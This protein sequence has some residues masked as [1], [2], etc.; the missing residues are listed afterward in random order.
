MTSGKPSETCREASAGIEVITTGYPSLDLIFKVNKAP[1]VGET[2]IISSLGRSVTYG[3]CGINVAAG[4]AKLGRK[5]AV[6][7]VVGED[8]ESTGY[9]A[10]LRSLGVDLTAVEVVPGHLTSRS[11]LYTTPEGEHLNFFYPG[12]ADVWS[13]D[14]IPFPDLSGARFAVVTVGPPR[15]NQVFVDQVTELSIPI[16]LQFRLDS[17]SYLSKDLGGLLSRC[18]ILLANRY[19]ADYLVQELRLGGYADLM[20]YVRDF[21]VITE[22]ENGVRVVSRD[23]VSRV[24][25]VKP[26][27][28]VD[29]TGAGD[30]FTAGLLYGLLRGVDIVDAARTGAALAS[31]VIEEVGCQTNLPS[32]Q[33]LCCRMRESYGAVPEGLFDEDYL[34]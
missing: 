14:T 15:Y 10:H 33:S 11:Y 18:R 13:N 27:R 3:G 28:I 12:A 17:Y 23:G 7:T 20:R 4:L 34:S 19:E 5:V 21:V 26:Q 16:V 31:F 1:S 9:A 25:S 32:L 24:P 22:G 30:G 29:T 6:G 2:A 8:F